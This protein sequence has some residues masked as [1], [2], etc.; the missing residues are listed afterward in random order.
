MNYSASPERNWTMSIIKTKIFH[1]FLQFDVFYYYYPMRLAQVLFVDAPF[2][3]K[4]IW[5]LIKP[6]IKS[7]ASLVSVAHFNVQLL[8]Y[9][10]RGTFYLF[11]L[12]VSLYMLGSSLNSRPNC[13]QFLS[14]SFCICL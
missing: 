14:A 12:N 3:F 13:T 10:T 7:Y 4:P 6:L 1:C 9:K 5:L 2:V 8:T 11:L